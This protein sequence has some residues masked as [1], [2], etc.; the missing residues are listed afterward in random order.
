MNKTLAEQPWRRLRVP[1]DDWNVL[2]RCDEITAVRQEVVIILL[3]IIVG[4]YTI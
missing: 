1:D 3:I 2:R 4:T